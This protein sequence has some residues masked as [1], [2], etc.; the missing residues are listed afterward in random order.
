MTKA[1]GKGLGKGLV[2]GF[3]LDLTCN[4]PD[5]G[6]PW[7]FDRLE[8]REK[9]RARCRTEKSAMLIGSPCCTAWCSWQALLSTKGDKGHR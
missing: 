7:D 3:A 5:D 2:A 9:A 6:M 1:I 8:K 4:D